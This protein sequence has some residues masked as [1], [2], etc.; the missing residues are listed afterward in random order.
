MILNWAES[1]HASYGYGS[2]LSRCVE[3]VEGYLWVLRYAKL[4]AFFLIVV[5]LKSVTPKCLFFCQWWCQW[6]IKVS[7]TTETYIKKKKR[8]RTAVASSEWSWSRW[9]LHG[10]VLRVA[11]L[12]WL[13]GVFWEL[14]CIFE[15][16]FW[17][18]CVE[19]A[20]IN[21]WKIWNEEINDMNYAVAVHTF[22]VSMTEAFIT[23]FS[24]LK[25]CGFH[26]PLSL[27]ISVFYM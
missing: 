2:V 1:N 22:I 6:W 9:Q 3:L 7:I 12:S 18:H 13:L 15:R 11:R 20:S 26:E 8:W 16:V 24:L 5:V 14:L 23:F 25:C 4:A 17:L 10:S 19:N 21:K 27:C